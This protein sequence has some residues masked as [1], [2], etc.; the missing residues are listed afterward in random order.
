MDSITAGPHHVCANSTN[1]SLL[2]RIEL[3]NSNSKQVFCSPT[4]TVRGTSFHPFIL[5]SETRPEKKGTG[6]TSH[7]DAPAE[8]AGSADDAS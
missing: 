1:R 5:S 6:T 4:G 3:M 8:S 2:H 7:T